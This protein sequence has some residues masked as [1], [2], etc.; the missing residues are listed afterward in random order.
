MK[1]DLEY[2]PLTSK[3]LPDR[4]K[5]L[6]SVTS[7]IGKQTEEWK[8][9]EVGD[10][11]LNLVF[12]VHGKEASLIVKQALP[13]VRIIG[14]SWPLPLRRAFFE[15]ETL[16]RQ[17]ARDPGSVPKI[18]YF[19]EKQAIIVMEMLSPPSI[20]RNKLIS[21]E[22]LTGLAITLVN[23]C[24]R[25]SFRASH[26]SLPTIEKNKDSALFQGNVDLTR[27]T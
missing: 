5:N 27:I 19:N 2:E 12:V 25:P 21:A 10:G 3:T 26:L 6:A 8:V 24:S 23:F 9:T 16:T 1:D 17:A 15:H 14:D 7:L 13:Y 20:L 4:L 11:N 18:H 22:S